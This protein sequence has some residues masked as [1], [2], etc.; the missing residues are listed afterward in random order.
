MR[1]Q[2]SRVFLL[3]LYLASIRDNQI[4]TK[5]FDRHAAVHHRREG[6]RTIL[7]HCIPV[8]SNE[9][10]DFTRFVA[11]FGGH[12]FFFACNDEKKKCLKNKK[13]SNMV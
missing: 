11:T 8:S 4:D 2:T 7:V 5:R 6:E 10:Q 3:V 13:L 1:P 9:V 12:D